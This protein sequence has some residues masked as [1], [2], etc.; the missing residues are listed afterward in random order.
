MNDSIDK[1]TIGTIGVQSFSQNWRCLTVNS[2]SYDSANVDM[3]L[4]KRLL[5]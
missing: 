5:Q 2:A 3:Q 1:V 4:T